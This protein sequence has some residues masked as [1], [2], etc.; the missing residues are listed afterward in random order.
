M[1][2]L[3][4]SWW[5]LKVLRMLFSKFTVINLS[6]N[7]IYILL[8]TILFFPEKSI[9]LTFYCSYMY[10]TRNQLIYIKVI[11]SLQKSLNL[12][13]WSLKIYNIVDCYYWRDFKTPRNDKE[14]KISCFQINVTPQTPLL[15]R[16]MQHWKILEKKTN[17][18]PK[19]E[20]CEVRISYEVLLVEYKKK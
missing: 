12:V 1:L 10:L 2:I 20:F 9:P 6:F 17:S 18:M 16:S 13:E 7:F 3:F 14:K 19:S 15:F 5:T 11:S 8:V 4:R